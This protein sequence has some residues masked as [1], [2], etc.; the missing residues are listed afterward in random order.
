MAFET[1]REIARQGAVT[2]C[3]GGTGV[4]EAAARGARL[5]GGTVIGI[6]PGCGRDEG[7]PFLSYAVA[8]GLGEARNAVITRTA[9]AVI[10][11]GGEYGTLSEI[12]LA[13]KMGKPVVTL[14]SWKIEAPRPLKEEVIRA[15]HPAEAV[16][17]ALRLASR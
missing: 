2:I 15:A 16:N 8:T 9:D 11:V 6:L 4:M 10:A 14:N 7:N 5:G 1:G 12:A 3:G 13:M 17:L